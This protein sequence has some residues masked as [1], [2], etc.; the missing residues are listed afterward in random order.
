MCDGVSGR[1]EVDN[2][3]TM[4]AEGISKNVSRIKPYVQLAQKT[5]KKN[6]IPTTCAFHARRLSHYKYIFYLHVC[7]VMHFSNWRLHVVTISLI[8]NSSDKMM[9]A[10]PTERDRACAKLNFVSA[11][12]GSLELD[13]L[14][15]HLPSGSSTSDSAGQ[16]ERCLERDSARNL[17]PGERFLGNTLGK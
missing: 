5:E 8:R 16:D 4:E 12:A 11:R 15:R 2:A 13:V 14:L 9:P 6:T 3:V 10:N 17:I 7:T 1:L